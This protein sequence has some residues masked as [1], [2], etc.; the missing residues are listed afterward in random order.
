MFDFNLQNSDIKSVH[1]I[2]IG[3]VSMSGIA[4]L[5]FIKG[6][7]VSGSDIRANKYVN[8]L[9]SIGI[10]VSIG[11]KK[12]NIKDQELFVYTDAIL[13]SNEELI[14]AKASGRPCLSRGEFLGALMR[15]YTYSIAVSGSHGKSSTTSMISDILIRTDDDPTILLGGSL[16]EIGGNVL[17]GSGDYFLAEACEYKGNIRYY[18]PSIAIVL[19]V[20]E[21]HLDYYKDLDDIVKAFEAYMDNLSPCALAIINADD[22]NTVSLPSHV[23]GKSYLY[24]IK[25]PN[26][27]RKKDYEFSNISFDSLGRPAFD[28][29]F[30][31]GHKEHYQLGI[32]GRFNIYNAVASIIACDI[33]GVDRKLIK[34]GIENYRSL[35]RRM[36]HV[37]EFKGANVISDYGHHPVEI[38]ATLEALAEHKQGKLYCVFQPYTMSRTRT[39]MEDFAKSFSSADLAIITKIQIAREVDDGSV[40]SEELV[41]KIN[42]RHDRAIYQET[43]EDCLNY[44]K[45][46]VN[47]G[48]TIL[49]TGC[50]DVDELADMLVSYKDKESAMVI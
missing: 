29:D 10:D 12:E 4:E 8:H 31:D 13:S 43:F 27:S 28:L 25:D 30:P 21:D 7:K 39:L 1:F 11:Q 47:E 32:I 6:F 36:E 26:S 40:K 44:L 37:G 3:G 2:G 33:T 17:A 45:D 41:E 15:N 20:D 5:L 48:D 49:A 38:R 24:G 50:G 34:S 9:I 46:I 19:N 35:H 18:Y 16:E 14:A 42:N 23:K 22:P